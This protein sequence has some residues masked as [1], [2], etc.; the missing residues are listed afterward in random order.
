MAKATRVRRLRFA[1][2]RLLGRPKKP[3]VVVARRV[4]STDCFQDFELIAICCTYAEQDIIAATVRNA[5]EQGCDQ[6]LLIDNNSPDETVPRAVGEGAETVGSLEMQVHDEAV[7]MAAINTVIRSRSVDTTRP[8]WWLLLDADEFP[9]G[10]NGSTV[11]EH[12]LSID[13]NTR[14]VGSTFFNHYPTERPAYVS[15]SHPIEFQPLGERELYRYCRRGHYKHPLIRMDPGGEPIEFDH[16]G[17]LPS[18]GSHRWLE[19]TVGIVTHHFQFR[20]ES[21]TR[22]RLELMS[23]RVDRERPVTRR[24]EVVDAVYAGEWSRVRLRRTRF[25]NRP[26]KLQPQSLDQPPQERRLRRALR[27]LRTYVASSEGAESSADATT[28]QP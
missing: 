22:S 14:V 4:S 6:F 13:R 11:R 16:G 18:A 15:G 12:L 23:G 25:G 7:R 9:V 21:D 5:F 17:H 24:M 2:R 19:A 10:P 1:S 20:E 26:I 3:T 8:I 27:S 28:N